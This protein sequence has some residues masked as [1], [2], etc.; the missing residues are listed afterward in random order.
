[1]TGH[2]YP[3]PIF[4]RLTDSHVCLFQELLPHFNLKGQWCKLQTESTEMRSSERML[5]GLKCQYS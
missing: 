4:V 2:S 3:P 5:P 1:M